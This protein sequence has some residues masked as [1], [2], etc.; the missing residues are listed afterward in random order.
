[1]NTIPDA[2]RDFKC[3]THLRDKAQERRTWSHP[4][5]R[6][7]PQRQ[8]IMAG[9]TPLRIIAKPPLLSRTG[10][11]SHSHRECMEGRYEMLS[12]T[13]PYSLAVSMRA[14]NCTRARARLMCRAGSEPRLLNLLYHRHGKISSVHTLLCMPNT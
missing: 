3:S 6:S 12:L 1:M 13:R 2:Y 14:W 11:H 7:L 4:F 9:R 8:R 10:Y 5:L